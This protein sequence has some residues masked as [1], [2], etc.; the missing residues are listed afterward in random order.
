MAYYLDAIK[1]VNALLVNKYFYL[2]SPVTRWIIT[3]FQ[4]S[5]L[6]YNGPQN[7]DKRLSSPYNK[8]GGQDEKYK[9]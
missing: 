5:N 7:L 4:R 6:I 3:N 9:K 1:R 2:L 8:V